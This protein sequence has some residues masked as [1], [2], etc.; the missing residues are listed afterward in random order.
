MEQYLICKMPSKRSL[1]IKFK[2]MIGKIFLLRKNKT[3]PYYSNPSSNCEGYLA[4][5][6]L[7]DG[8]LILDESNTRVQIISQK[9]EPI[10]IGKYYIHKE[11]ETG[12]N[13]NKI[14][15][16]ME[17]IQE[18]SQLCLKKHEKELQLILSKLK[19]LEELIK[20]EKK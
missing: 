5:E 2:P 10:W 7:G 1:H 4:R 20:N 8:V 11:I 19:T 6:S 16:L 14:E 17:I 13:N 15:L 18:T 12:K 9:N 3:I